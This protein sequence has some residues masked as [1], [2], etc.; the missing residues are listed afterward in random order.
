MDGLRP[1]TTPLPF[2]PSW[3][4]EAFWVEETPHPVLGPRWCLPSCVIGFSHVKRQGWTPQ[5]AGPLRPDVLPTGASQRP[6][7]PFLVG[8]SRAWGAP[9]RH[10]P[11]HCPLVTKG[12][13]VTQRL[14]FRTFI[15]HGPGWA[16]G[17]LLQGCG[18]WSR[19][20]LSGQA[21]RSW[22]PGGGIGR[23][24]WGPPS[25]RSCG[26]RPSPPDTCGL[27]S[28]APRREPTWVE[29]GGGGAG[30]GP[31]L[32]RSWHGSPT[33]PPP[34]HSR[35]PAPLPPRL[36]ILGHHQAACLGHGAHSSRE[37]LH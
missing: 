28:W 2:S 18:S 33:P 31:G 37:Y 17:T 30:Q 16:E 8:P 13:E 7:P 25:R 35:H 26:S 24:R 27:G 6:S 12:R 34:T 19:P 5:P 14:A 21:V 32:T 29:G 22:P 10:L 36:H 11:R 15:P 1:I 23:A 3:P 4:G 20:D 9:P